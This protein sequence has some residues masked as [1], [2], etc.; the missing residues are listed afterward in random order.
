MELHERSDASDRP[1]TALYGLAAVAILYLA[2]EILVPVALAILL[3][4]VVSPLV[5]RI[6][7]RVRSRALS[8]LLATLLV[9]GV[10]GSGLIFA[11]QQFAGLAEDLP[12]YRT[13]IVRK[14]RAVQAGPGRLIERIRNFGKDITQP[15][16]AIEG[17]AESAP[18]LPEDVVPAPVPAPAEAIDESPIGW[19]MISPLIEPL[20]FAAIVIVLLILM[21]MAR[22]N[23]RDRIIR[24]AGL[25]QI[26]FTTQTLEEAGTRVSRY[27]RAQLLLNTTFGGAVTI[28]L[29]I[30]GLPNAILCGV[31]AGV[32]RFIPILGPWIAAIIPSA[33]ALAVFDDWSH[34]IIVASLFAALELVWNIVLEPWLYGTS[35]GL[36]SL[37]VILAIIFWTWVWGAIGLMLAVPMTVCI[38]VFTRHVPALSALSILLGNEPVL[39]ESM[40]YYQRLLC[41]DEEEASAILAAAPADAEPAAVADEIVL[42][43]LSAARQDLRRGLISLAQAERIAA[44]GRELALEWLQDKE[45]PPPAATATGVVCIPASDALDEAAAAVLAEL[46]RRGGVQA[47]LVPAALLISEKIEAAAVPGVNLI[48]VCGVGPGVDRPIRRIVKTLKQRLP[49][50]PLIVASWIAE[51]PAGEAAVEPA[52]ADANQASSHRQ[53][54]TLVKSLVPVQPPPENPP[55]GGTSP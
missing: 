10:I 53:A 5:T 21:L 9:V 3:T 33:L 41:R 40:R 17:P 19:D 36:S 45:A 24:L 37:G 43:G 42:P 29:V 49:T 1:R 4:F 28:G 48:V 44:S 20:A 23:I 2:R 47:T 30:I 27:L 8:V 13:T 52:S 55:R 50:L 35:T 14:V 11:G 54:I 7:R 34:V 12:A 39:P 32:L 15:E 38:V 25:H 16:P 18:A 6:E 46:L 22:E 31:L 26:G 51:P